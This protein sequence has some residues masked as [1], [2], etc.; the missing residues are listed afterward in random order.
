MPIRGGGRLSRCR[1]RIGGG[2]GRVLCAEALESCPKVMDKEFANA[3]D[4]A[5]ALWVG[6]VAVDHE[7]NT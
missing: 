2:T 3:S 5:G 7:D 4:L 6:L 1:V